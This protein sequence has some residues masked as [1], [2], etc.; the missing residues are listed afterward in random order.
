MVIDS[1]KFQQFCNGQPDALYKEAYPSL[2]SM[3]NRMLSPFFNYLAED[4]VQEAVCSAWRNRDNLS[5]PSHLKSYLFACVHNEAVNILRKNNKKQLFFQQQQQNNLNW[6]L[7]VDEQYLIQE[8]LDTLYGIIDSLPNDYKKIFELS[9]VE[10]LKL[11]EVAQALNLSLSGVKKRKARFLEML[12]EKLSEHGHDPLIWM[13][14]LQICQC[15]A[16]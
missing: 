15:L 14:F 13:M 11:E 5:S 9:F 10:G 7:G 1:E 6:D 2:L 3:A 8:S 4:C 12:R 16:E